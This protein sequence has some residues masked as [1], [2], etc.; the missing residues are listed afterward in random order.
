MTP[1]QAELLGNKLRAE[2]A[3]IGTPDHKLADATL[4]RV[5]SHV[6]RVD[7]AVDAMLMYPRP[8]WLVEIAGAHWITPGSH[9]LDDARDIA[10]RDEWG[11]L[12]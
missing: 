5:V 3:R 6:G 8:L 4:R 12:G 11:P 1:E 10:T 9:E 2:L 7:I